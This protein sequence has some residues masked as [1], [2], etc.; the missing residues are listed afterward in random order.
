MYNP[1]SYCKHIKAKTSKLNNADKP[2]KLNPSKAK[3]HFLFFTILFYIHIHWRFSTASTHPIE[4][5][6][7][8][9]MPRGHVGMHIHVDMPR[10]HVGMHTICMLICPGGMLGCISMFT[11]LEGVSAYACCHAPWHPDMDMHVVMSPGKMSGGMSHS[12][13]VGLLSRK[14]LGHF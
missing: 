7:H 3:Q 13:R 12:R 11:C 5:H 4:M 9:D 1:Q 6:I 2:S 8:V 10:G 14:I